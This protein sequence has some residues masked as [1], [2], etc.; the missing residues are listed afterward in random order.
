MMWLKYREEKNGM[1][2]VEREGKGFMTF[3]LYGEECYIEDAYVVPEFRQ[4]HV[5]TEMLKEIESI[6]KLAGC[7]VISSCVRPDEATATLSMLAQISAGFKI[8]RS[9]LNKIVM[10][11]EIL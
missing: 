4:H 6:A 9:E 5:G 7:K 3:K 1:Q 10:V 11:K 8:H 2:S